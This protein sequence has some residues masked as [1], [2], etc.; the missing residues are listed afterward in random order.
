MTNNST[1]QKLRIIVLGYIIR[2]PLGGLAWHHL[3]Y[4]MGLR[5]LGHDVYFVEDSDDYP[6]CYDPVRNVTDTDPSYGLKFIDC[7]FRRVGIEDRWAYYNAHA[8]RWMGRCGNRIEEIFRT[9]DLL[10]N[11]SGVNPLRPWCCNVSNRALVDTDPAFTQ[12][13]HLTESKAKSFALK[14]NSFFSFGENIGH[15]FCTVPDDGLP[16]QPTRQPVVLDAWPLI[17]GPSTGKFTTVMQWDS[18]PTCEYRGEIYGMKSA[19]FEDYTDLPKHIGMVLEIALG[20]PTAPHRMLTQRGWSLRNSLKITQDP[21]TYQKYI[22][23][24]KAEFSVAKHGYVISN[25]GWF[26][27]RGAS[28]L[29]SG[30]PVVNQETGFSEWL[31]AEAGVLSFTTPE[32]AIERIK[33]INNRYEFH[34]KAART[35]AETYFDSDNVLKNLIEKALENNG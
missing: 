2:G 22:Q 26:S 35:F 4:I 34:C 23:Q 3:Q 21:W 27:E 6:S 20:S 33:E 14:H 25:S 31:K 9:A 13:R 7:I 29:A 1:D 12:I 16:W 17:P 24:S 19:S 15:E 18:Y 28:Y 32:E 5:R 10:L 8:S 11:L 30:R